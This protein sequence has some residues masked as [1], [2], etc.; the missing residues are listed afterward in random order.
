MEMHQIRYFLSVARDLNFS[1]A[2]QK[3]NVSR[4]SLS[5]AIQQLEG[6]LR[7]LLF[8]RERHLTHPRN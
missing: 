3:C 7:G 2:A 4:P 6:E 5:R 1:R 8:S